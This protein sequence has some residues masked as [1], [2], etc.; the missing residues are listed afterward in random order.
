M[1]KNIRVLNYM[2]SIHPTSE[3]AHGIPNRIGRYGLVKGDSPDVVVTANTVTKEWV[4]YDTDQSYK[5]DQLINLLLR[6]LRKS[7]KDQLHQ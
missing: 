3:S 6:D 4:S 2:F 5:S 7:E 1:R